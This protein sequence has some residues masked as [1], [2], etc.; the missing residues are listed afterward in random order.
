MPPVQ[1][2]SVPPRPVTGRSTSLNGSAIDRSQQADGIVYPRGLTASSR[3]EAVTAGKAAEAT[4][5]VWQYAAFG[6]GQ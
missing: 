6:K 4:A 3:H 2:W 5:S 1:V